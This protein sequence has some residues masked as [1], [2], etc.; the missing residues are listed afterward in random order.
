MDID[1]VVVNSAIDVAYDRVR[2]IVMAERARYHRMEK[3]S[4]GA[5]CEVSV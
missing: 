4:V 3:D 2:A 1:Y 5:F